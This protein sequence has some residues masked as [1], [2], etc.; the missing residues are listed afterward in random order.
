MH[1]V[2]ELQRVAGAFQVLL[3]H[4]G[5]HLQGLQGLHERAFDVFLDRDLGRFVRLLRFDLEGLGFFVGDPLQIDLLLN[6]RRVEPHQLVALR[7]FGAVGDDPQNRAAASDLAL[8]VQVV[9]ALE[10]AVLGNRDDQIRAAG[11]LGQHVAGSG[12]ARQQ[13]RT[14]GHEHDQGHHGQQSA[15]EQP[16]RDPSPATRRRGFARR[17]IAKYGGELGSVCFIFPGGDAHIEP[18][19]LVRAGGGGK[20]CRREGTAQGGRHR[21]VIVTSAQAEFKP[22]CQLRSRQQA[23]IGAESEGPARRAPAGY[24]QR[25]CVCEERSTRGYFRRPWPLHWLARH[26]A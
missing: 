13:A 6:A 8:D 10:R 22:D 1:A 26:L 19:I 17:S 23:A 4:G 2:G 24:R 15:D 11:F 16:T 20:S 18:Q 3:G 21:T 9:G 7:H 14:D 12:R 25:I 5:L